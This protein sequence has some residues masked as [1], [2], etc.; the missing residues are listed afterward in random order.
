MANHTWTVIFRTGGPMDCRWGRSYTPSATYQLAN[1]LSDSIQRMGYA[2]AIWRTD[3]LDRL[4][5]PV[6][7]T[8]DIVDWD[9]DEITMGCYHT[10]HRPARRQE[11]S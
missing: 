8:S 10:H 9:E 5:L 1:I 2:T 11:A 4:G 7:W 3:V 6:G